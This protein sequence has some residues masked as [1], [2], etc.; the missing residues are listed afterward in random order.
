M[1]MFVIFITNK[2]SFRKKLL[3]SSKSLIFPGVG[4]E[5]K[6][7]SVRVRFLIH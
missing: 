1:I 3:Q 4:L 5:K 6:I 2:L 7:T